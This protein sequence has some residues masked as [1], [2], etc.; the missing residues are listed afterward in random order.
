M[1]HTYVLPAVG[2]KQVDF[3][4]A[5]IL[6]DKGLLRQAIKEM[7]QAGGKGA[8]WVWGI[9]CDLHLLKYGLPFR[10]DVDATWDT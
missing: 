8:Q 2:N 9:Y 6:M 5:R 7:N 3:D 4:R 1:F 10:P